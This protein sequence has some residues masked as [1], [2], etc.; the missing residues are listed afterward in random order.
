MKVLDVEGFN[1]KDTSVLILSI[2]PV[3]L[4]YLVAYNCVALLVKKKYPKTLH[5]LHKLNLIHTGDMLTFVGCVCG[6]TSISPD[7]ST[8]R[9]DY[10][11]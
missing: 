8:D 2:K 11:M 6:T 4:N 1:L 7:I 10:S 5:E 3:Q 9:R